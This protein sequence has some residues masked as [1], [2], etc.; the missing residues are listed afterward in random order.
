MDETPDEPGAPD[1]DDDDEEVD[2]EHRAAGRRGVLSGRRRAAAAVAVVVLAGGGAALALSGGGGDDDD[3]ASSSDDDPSAGE[4]DWQQVVPGGDCMCSDGSQFSF[5]VREANPNKVLFY[6]QAGGACFTAEMCAQDGSDGSEELYTPALGPGGD[7]PTQ[8][9]GIFDF[10]DERNPF[11]DYSVVYV[12][13]CTG[14]G[15]LGNATTEYAPGLTIQHKG[16]VNGTAALDHLAVTFPDATEIVVAGVSAGA[17]ATPV[18]G[19]LV[20][21]RLPDADIT[22]L[23]DGS[24]A[25]PPD[26]AGLSVRLA[27]VWGTGNAIPDWPENAGLTAE[28]WTSTPELFMQSGRHDPDITFARHDYAYDDT[29]ELF[30]SYAGVPA[31]DLLSMLDANETRIEEAVNLLTYMAPGDDHGVFLYESFYTE[32]V[33]G[34]KLVDWVSRL[35]EGETVND[36]HCDDGEAE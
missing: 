14:D 3:T 36:V 18:Y 4:S 25:T 35:V 15:H 13:Y 33:N 2:E 12:P 16:Y 29:Q 34:E 32:E 27:D 26:V 6:F 24:G 20:S 7:P 10:A 9:D 11:A 1:K 28:Q 22:V 23:A 19:G 31:N 8:W 21:D 30:A 5:W 17:F